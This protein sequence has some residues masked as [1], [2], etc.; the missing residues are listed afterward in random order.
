MAQAKTVAKPSIK[1]EKI[2]PAMA[3]KLLE[4]NF[5][6]Q[7]RLSKGAIAKLV[8]DIRSG[9]FAL[10]GDTIKID[11]NGK[12]IDG[13]HRL[14][15]IMQAGKPVELF[16]ARNVATDAYAT[17]D[18]GR[19]RSLGDYLHSKGV[20]YEPV[21]AAAITRI[22]GFIRSGGRLDQHTASSQSINRLIELFETE[23]DV[24]SWAPQAHRL[25]VMFR[26]SAGTWCALLYLA[27][28]T[29]AEDVDFFVE[30]LLSGEELSDGDPILLLRNAL[31][32][33]LTVRRDRR[34]SNEHYTS[35]VIRAWNAYA[36]G[37][38][39]GLLKGSVKGKHVELFDPHGILADRWLSQD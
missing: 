2:T 17:L 23:H 12:V 10:T 25:G 36:R 31:L 22:D 7:R 34:M 1:L 29:K 15:A 39:L 21:V 14:H 18:Q 37:E 11:I 6:G 13:Q 26:F 16:V 32:H 5:A 9:T 33:R 4:H 30:R 3:S 28:L 8:D 19:K 38:T 24:I 20:S 35:L 27:S